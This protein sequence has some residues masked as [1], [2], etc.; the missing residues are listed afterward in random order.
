[1]RIRSKKSI[2]NE[3]YTRRKEAEISVKETGYER[4][5]KKYRK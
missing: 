1:M 2:C 3:V 5:K 4:M